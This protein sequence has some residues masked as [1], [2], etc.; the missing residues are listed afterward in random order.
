MFGSTALCGFMAFTPAAGAV[1]YL[2][3]VQLFEITIASAGSSNTATISSVD[4][5]RSVIFLTG[6]TTTYSGTTLRDF[7]PSVTL[8]NSTTVT[9]QRGDVDASTVTV[10]GYVAE[11][12]SAAV[13]SVEYGTISLANG[14]GSNTATISAV[15]TARTSVFHLGQT[16]NVA[17]ATSTEGNIYHTL[18]LTDS[19]TITADRNA[20]SGASTV[21]FCAVQWASGVLQSMQTISRTLTSGNLSDT[22]TISSVTTGNTLLAYAGIRCSSST[23]TIYFYTLELTNG[24][25]VTYTRTATTS[26]SRTINYT[27]LEFIPGVLSQN[28]QRGTTAMN[29]ATQTDTAI[30]SVNTSKS[31]VNY[32]GFRISATGG[33]DQRSATIKLQDATTVRSDKAVGGGAGYTMTNSWEVAEFT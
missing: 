18:T 24:T 4:A 27:V 32:C 11:F 5:T 14:V 6:F 13:D 31:I 12:T 9:A 15:T 16:S 30:S 29:N 20:T 3:S 10:R 28:V 33:A 21:N 25:T 17:N 22:E 2:Q 26:T 8:T 23:E 1:T 19:T 7:I